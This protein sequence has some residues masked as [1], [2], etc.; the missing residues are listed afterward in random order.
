VLSR[1]VAILGATG[2]VGR[3]M[4]GILE[5]RAFPVDDLRLLASERSADRTMRFRG[6]DLAVQAVS[7][8][9]FEGVDVALFA[10]SADLSREWAPVANAAGAHVVDNSSAFRMDPRVPLVVPEVN[11]ALLES[12]PALVAN[13]NCVAIPLVMTLYPLLAIARLERVV[14]S[15]YQSVSGAGQ[16]ALDELERGARAGLDGPVPR[17]PDGR[18]PFAY[19]VIPHIDRFDDAGWT[20][21]ETKI[22]Q[23]ARRM[24]DLPGLTVAATSVRVPVRVGHSAAVVAWF[25]RGV[26]SSEA[27]TAWSGMPGVQVVDDPAHERYP[28]PIDAAGGDDVLVGRARRIEGDAHALAWFLS[29]DN[30]RKGAALNAV[31]VAERLCGGVATG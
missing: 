9:A 26:T 7:A 17:R 3:T 16:D 28:M 27:R 21:E 10:T 4:L 5:Q 29:S 22:A 2:L 24:L 23:E 30:L 25:D 12:R 8:A 1:T 18:P 13:G 14:V 31:Q 6:R 11:G 19:N 15:S 20:G